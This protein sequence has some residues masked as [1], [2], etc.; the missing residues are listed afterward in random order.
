M[1]RIELSFLT[2]RIF[3]AAVVAVFFPFVHV[4]LAQTN[5]NSENG[6]QAATPRVNLPL[7]LG[8]ARG[9]TALYITPE[10]GVDPSA[11]AVIVSTAQAVPKRFSANH[12]PPHFAVLPR[13]PP[14]PHTL[15]FTT[16]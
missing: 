1:R 5:S 10:V 2:R 4:T 15:T 8:F 9:G 12:I 14:L 13:P 16:H 6:E 3:L 7:Q 11:G